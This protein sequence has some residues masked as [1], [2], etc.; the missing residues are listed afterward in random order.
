MKKYYDL[1]DGFTTQTSMK[2]NYT[3]KSA[4]YVYLMSNSRNI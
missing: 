3:N 4:T 2:N 1:I